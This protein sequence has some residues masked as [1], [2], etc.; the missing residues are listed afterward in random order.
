MD[1]LNKTTLRNW[2]LVT[3][4]DAPPPNQVLWGTVKDDPSFRWYPGDWCCTSPVLQVLDDGIHI[5]KN[6]RYSVEGPG[7]HIELPV[8]ALIELRQGVAPD[9]WSSL[10]DLKHQG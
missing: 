8:K 6:T 4:H 5:T 2:F 10:K 1:L 9:Q 3:F 7:Q